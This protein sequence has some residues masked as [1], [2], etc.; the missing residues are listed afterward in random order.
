MHFALCID[1]VED[2]LPLT[3]TLQLRLDYIRPCLVRLVVQDD[4]FITDLY[5]YGCITWPQRNHLKEG[6]D[7]W[8]KN[9]KLIDFIRRRSIANY[10]SF[11]DCLAKHHQSH[12]AQLLLCAGGK[13]VQKQSLFVYKCKG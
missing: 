5:N 2:V 8:Y 6:R 3:K 7:S 4:A 10:N 1:N 9:E 13:H 11:A 12:V